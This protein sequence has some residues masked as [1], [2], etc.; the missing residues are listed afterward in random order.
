[1]RPHKVHVDQGPEYNGE[2]YIWC[3]CMTP[4][5]VRPVQYYG[6]TDPHVFDGLFEGE[7]I[8][9]LTAWLYE[10]EI[11]EFGDER[12]QAFHR[13]QGRDHRPAVH[14]QAAEDTAG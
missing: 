9:A 2:T 5:G 1:M 3:E 10:H 11:L 7:G 14:Q 4:L 8:E 6:S 12:L 13:A